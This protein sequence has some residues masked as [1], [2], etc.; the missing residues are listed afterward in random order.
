MLLDWADGNINLLLIKKE[1]FIESKS[2][3][4]HSSK[5]KKS[6]FKFQSLGGIDL[7]T[8]ILLEKT[9]MD[10]VTLVTAMNTND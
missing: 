2:T 4:P 1:I 7:N 9:F 10:F 3:S 6:A 8:L 5:T